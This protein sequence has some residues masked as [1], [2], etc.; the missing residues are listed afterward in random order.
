MNFEK[1]LKTTHRD[2]QRHAISKE[3]HSYVLESLSDFINKPDEVTKDERP[4]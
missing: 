4:K 1:I 3:K 2:Q